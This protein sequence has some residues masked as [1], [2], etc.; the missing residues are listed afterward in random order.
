MKIL[1]SKKFEP[2][3]ITK[4]EKTEKENIKLKNEVIDL[5]TKILDLQKYFLKL[6]K[7]KISECEVE[8]VKSVL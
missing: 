2:G 3:I 8:N 4:L 1:E 7:E 5:Q 6:K